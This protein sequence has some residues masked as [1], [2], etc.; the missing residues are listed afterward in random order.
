MADGERNWAGNFTYSANQIVHARSVAQLQDVARKAGNVRALG[1]RHTFNDLADTPD[2]LVSLTEIDPD[3]VINTEERTLTIGAGTRY[4]IAARFLQDRGWALHNMG[5]LPHICIGGA[6]ATGTHGSGSRNGNLSTAVAGF[7]LVTADGELLHITRENPDFSKMVVGLGAFGLVTRV[8][9]D[10]Q[11]T[12][13]IRQDAYTDMPWETFIQ[14][15]DAV[16]DAGYSVSVFTD[17]KHDVV[18]QIWLKSKVS[19]DVAPFDSLIGAPRD[20]SGQARLADSIAGNLTPHGSIGPWLDRLPH[21]RLET[22]PSLGAEIQSEY[23]IDR[24]HAADALRAVRSIAHLFDGVLIISELRTIAAD[25]L[26]LSPAF[27]RPTFAFHFTWTDDQEAVNGLLPILEAALQPFDAR[28]HWGKAN[29]VSLG[30]LETSYVHLES[31]RQLVRSY[32]PTG[33]FR[34]EYLK[35]LGI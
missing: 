5:S 17:W 3:P 22:T 16:M 11:P 29:S 23:F 24:S 33:K 12:Y 14:N 20:R 30:T 27:G 25:Q 7:E 31:F 26:A 34:N 9:I 10:I 32:D 19:Q 1:T 4:G 2:T 21:F 13:Q 15:V 6:T 28:P 35:R 8:T 18:E